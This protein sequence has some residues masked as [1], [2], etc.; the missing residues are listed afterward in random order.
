MSLPKRRQRPRSGIVRNPDRI[1]SNAHLQFVRGFECVAV[2]SGACEGPIQA[3]HI[4]D[5][6]HAG[7]GQKPDDDLTFP[8]C[9]KHHARQHALGEAKFEMEYGVDLRRLAG[10]LAW[11]SPALRRLAR[12]QQEAQR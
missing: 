7:M 4:R 6:S 8:A 9:A 11:L 3:C 2:K 5:G 10:D 1:R 12:A